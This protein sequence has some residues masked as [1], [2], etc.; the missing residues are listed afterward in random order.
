[1]FGVNFLV[2]QANSSELGFTPNS[3]SQQETTKATEPTLRQRLLVM[4]LKP[5]AFTAWLK[6]RLVVEFPR[7][8][9]PPIKSVSK[10]PAAVTM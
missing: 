8:E 5:P 2:V 4:R 9:L 3:P 6:V 7:R 10:V 1:M